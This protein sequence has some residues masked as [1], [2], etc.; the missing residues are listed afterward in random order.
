MDFPD[1]VMNSYGS[2]MNADGTCLVL[3]DF[4]TANITTIKL[5]T[6]YDFKTA[7]EPSVTPFNQT[8]KWVWL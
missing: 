8:E 2:H 4:A 3:N 5:N 6:P 7:E 1:A